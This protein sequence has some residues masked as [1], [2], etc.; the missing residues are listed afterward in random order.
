MR[1]RTALAAAFVV[2]AAG[3]GVAS[4]STTTAP[5]HIIS[6]TQDDRGICVTISLQTTHCVPLN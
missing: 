1:I 4:A 2:V 5:P 3:A 6:V